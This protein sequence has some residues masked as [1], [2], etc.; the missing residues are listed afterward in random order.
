MIRERSSGAEHTFRAKGRRSDRGENYPD[1]GLL[2]AQKVK[3]F[4]SCRFPS[5]ND[6]LVESI[7]EAFQE[8]ARWLICR[9]PRSASDRKRAG[10]VF[11]E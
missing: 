6:F 1:W 4:E 11:R 10:P 7:R 2:P 9:R 8:T 5:E 3:R